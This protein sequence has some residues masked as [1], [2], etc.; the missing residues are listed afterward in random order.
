MLATAI[1][2]TIT[3]L[4]ALSSSILEERGDQEL[5]AHFRETQDPKVI[6]LLMTR[7]DGLIYGMALKWL[8]DPERARDFAGDLFVKL[9]EHLQK[10]EVDNFP[11][12]LGR[13]TRNRLHDLRRKDQVRDDYKSVFV[14]PEAPKIENAWDFA[15]DKQELKSA[16]ESLSDTEQ[17]VIRGVYFEGKSYQEIGEEYDW[18]FNQ[19]RGARERAIRKLRS[20]LPSDYGNYFKD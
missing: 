2:L 9:F 15:M 14:P 4:L 17:T 10:Q 1:I 11:A 18:S 12:W 20:V 5:L 19:V 7:Y 3:V 16:L 8:R 13:T 6:A